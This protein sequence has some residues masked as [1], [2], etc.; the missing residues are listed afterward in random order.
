[1]AQDPHSEGVPDPGESLLVSLRGADLL[2]DPALNKG[3]GFSIAE[4]EAFALSGLMP[5]GLSTLKEQLQRAYENYQ[6]AQDDLQRYRSLED[7]Q[8]RN[9]TLFYRLL[10]DNIEEMA[11]IVYTPTVGAVCAAYSHLYRRPHGLYV[12]AVHRGRIETVLRRAPVRDCRIIV[13]TDNEAI[14]GL[15]D[16]GVGGMRIPVG[17][18][19]L[20]T[21]GAGIL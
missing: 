20:Y 2:S 8:D 4:R 17:K 10:V 15:G 7:L 14:L 16:L 3:T 1:M 18:L 6:L 5:P 9:E 19:T 13:L 12:S 21:A 11:P